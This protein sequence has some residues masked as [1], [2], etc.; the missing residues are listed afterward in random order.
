MYWRFFGHF[1]S[2]CTVFNKTESEG[3]AGLRGAQRVFVRRTNGIATYSGVKTEALDQ[4]TSFDDWIC[5]LSHWHVA[6]NFLARSFLDFR[7]NKIDP[8]AQ[9]RLATIASAGRQTIHIRI[10]YCSTGLKF[11][12]NTYGLQKKIPKKKFLFIYEVDRTDK[13]SWNYVGPQYNK[14]ALIIT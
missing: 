2:G 10:Q 8:K 7:E 12:R 3:N 9:V 6:I 11:L 5:I 13:R 1:V 4:Q 14:N